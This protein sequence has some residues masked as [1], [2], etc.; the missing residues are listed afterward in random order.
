[1][2][3]LSQISNVSSGNVDITAK[4]IGAGSVFQDTCNVCLVK[5]YDIMLTSKVAKPTWEEDTFTA[6]FAFIIESIFEEEE[7]PYS[8]FYQQHQITEAILKG[9]ERPQ[10]AKKMDIVFATFS[11]PKLSYGIEAK[12]IAES[13]LGK[14]NA[15]YLCKEYIISGVDRFVNGTYNMDGCMI[16][17]VVSGVPD[18]IIVKINH[19]LTSLD[20]GEEKVGNKHDIHGHVSC[21]VSNHAGFS[22]QHMLFLFN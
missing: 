11:R 18:N 7:L 8:V 13:D 16:G 10:K 12:I 1:M 15:N 14:R 20:R 17:Y 22:L 6:N 9:T 4:V 5:A 3:T 21:Y 2:S 19:V